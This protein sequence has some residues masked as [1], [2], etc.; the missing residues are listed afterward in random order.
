MGDRNLVCAGREPDGRDGAAMDAADAVILPQGCSPALY[1]MATKRC[2]HVFP[3]YAARF[4]YDGKL[5]QIRLFRKTAA[6]HPRSFLFDNCDEYHRRVATEGFPENLQFPLVFKFN[7]GGEGFTVYRLEDQRQLRQQIAVAAGLERTGQR[8]FLLQE[9]IATGGRILRV[10]CIGERFFSYWR[11]ASRPNRFSVS[12]AKGASIDHTGDPERQR[13]AIA[14]VARYGR[15]TGIN[16][17]GFD[18]VFDVKN[19]QPQPLMLEI[20][21]FFGRS[22]L[23]GSQRYYDILNVEIHRWLATHGLA[24]QSQ[25]TNGEL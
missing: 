18:L 25:Q 5:G 17:A 24:V 6:P 23:G 1:A 21:Y 9:L 16:L 20:N 10:V 15:Q 11:V 4:D 14:S 22:G 8:G 12:R 7:W 13:S 2:R 3:N 19:P